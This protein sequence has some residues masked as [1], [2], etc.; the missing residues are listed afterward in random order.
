MGSAGRASSSSVI[1]AA[2]SLSSAGATGTV[3][4]QTGVVSLVG[5]AVAG[6]SSALSGGVESLEADGP[7]SKSP[8]V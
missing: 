5:T 1:A 2:S 8:S 4:A 6:S 7:V 3:F